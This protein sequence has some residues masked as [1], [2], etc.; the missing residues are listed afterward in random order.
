MTTE[1][2]LA[3]LD[4]LVARRGIPLSV[5]S[6]CGRNFV[7]AARHLKEFF[8][9]LTKEEVQMCIADRATTTGF[10]WHFN[11][12]YAPHF[13][14]L[15]EAAV[16]SVKYHLYRVIRDQILS[17]EELTTLFA[18]IEAILN[19]RPIGSKGDDSGGLDP[20]TPG[21]FLTGGPLI[22]IPEPDLTELRI[23]RLSRWQLIQNAA[24]H[25]WKRWHA[26]YLSTLQKRTK[27]FHEKGSLD[28]G[29]V[30]LMPDPSSP[31]QRWPLATVLQCHP[32]ADGVVR[33]VSIQSS[34]GIQRRSVHSLVP[35]SQL[36]SEP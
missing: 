9:W 7:G 3:S 22:S 20:L 29:D 33:V 28:V 31:R 19:S 16:K 11:P 13:G 18:K 30:V 5:S 14:G 36:K 10:Q 1:A 2:F 24:Q 26:E 35:L 27:W 21:H 17:F 6:D 32:G 25:F 15:W 12:P 34:K 23:N 8:S 4:R